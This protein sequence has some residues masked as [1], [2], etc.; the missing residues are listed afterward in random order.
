[1]EPVVEGTIGCW[2]SF[3]FY[4]HNITYHLIGLRSLGFITKAYDKL[5]RVP[6]NA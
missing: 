3:G 6:R 1:M 4:F 2:V 5:K